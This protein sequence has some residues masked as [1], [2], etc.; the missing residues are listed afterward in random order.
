MI[1]TTPRTG[2]N[3]L[4]FELTLAG[5]GEPDEYLRYALTEE[6][7][8]RDALRWIWDRHTS[9]GIFGVKVHWNER[10]GIRFIDVLPPP[11]ESRLYVY[12]RRGDLDIQARSWAL[13]L[14][15]QTWMDRP[16]PGAV[17]DR[18]LVA[19]CRSQLKH[20]NGCWEEWFRSYGIE[21]LRITYEQM[22]ID[23][24]FVVGQIGQ[25]VEQL[26]SGRWMIEGRR[27]RHSGMDHVLRS[28]G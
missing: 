6:A 24:A 15:Y 28:T 3:W 23:V 21:P 8:I 4:D 25:R 17:A 20:M 7:S 12:L 27:L 5:L 16:P 11:P 1:C 9:A 14:T 2:G 22:L 13:A 26:P 18:T 10:Y 19:E